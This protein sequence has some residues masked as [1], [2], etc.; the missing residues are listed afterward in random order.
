MNNPRIV[1]KTALR[2]LYE[3]LKACSTKT[4]TDICNDLINKPHVL[5]RY[6]MQA[7]KQMK[8]YDNIEEDFTNTTYERKDEDLAKS[9]D[10]LLKGFEAQGT[11]IVKDRPE[12]SFEYKNKEISP[13]RTTRAYFNDGSPAKSSGA[14]GLDMIAVNAKERYPILGEVKI[15]SDENAFYA[16]IQ[17]LTYCSEIS[18]P[19]QIA[20]INRW[21]L[22]EEDIKNQFGL[23][24]ILF[25]KVP[26]RSK[27]HDLISMTHE[28]AKRFASNI[29]YQNASIRN[30]ACL[31]CKKERDVF[32]CTTLWDV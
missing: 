21:E 20:R 23:Y 26:I 24:I 22:F 31:E 7:C 14:G 16:F 29:A 27:K 28:L 12:F 8:K 25:N 11:I 32:Q 15:G 18:S 4:Q 13:L 17:L 6:Y 2:H 9:T 1:P 5:I 30:I 3:L 19:N 10:K